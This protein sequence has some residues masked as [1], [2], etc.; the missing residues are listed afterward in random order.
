MNASDQDQWDTLSDEMAQLCERPE[1]SL[2]SGRTRPLEWR[3]NQL[4]A[5]YRMI[6]DNSDAIVSALQADLA[7]PTFEAW[8]AEV[9]VAL[10]DIKETMK[11]LSGWMRPE[12]VS[13]NGHPAG[14]IQNLQRSVGRRVD[15]IRLEL[16]IQPH[17]CPTHRSHLSRQCCFS[18]TL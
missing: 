16:P 9:G 15:H 8:A 1:S 14:Q 11:K 4:Q 17:D 13:I 6:E 10:R 5:M 2:D 7:K 12:R 3:M 18:Q